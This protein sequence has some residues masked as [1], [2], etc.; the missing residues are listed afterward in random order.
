[1]GGEGR[2][3]GR[4]VGGTAS[5]Q[6]VSRPTRRCFF[7]QCSR[8]VPQLIYSGCLVTVIRVVSVSHALPPA[9]RATELL[10]VS[11]LSASPLASRRADLLLGGPRVT[12]LGF[13]DSCDEAV[14]TQ[15]DVEV[16]CTGGGN[17]SLRVDKLDQARVAL[18][19]FLNGAR[20]RGVRD[21][22]NQGTR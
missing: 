6:G 18:Q 1:V 21:R 10:P 9:A 2:K 8:G 17:R 15:G 14:E 16:A 3:E 11:T 7:S 20:L 13:V 12:I 19:G 22:T 4:L 5:L